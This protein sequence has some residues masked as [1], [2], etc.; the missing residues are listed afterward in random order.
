MKKP[1]A[2]GMV[3]T[4][5]Y[6]GA[7]EKL[8]SERLQEPVTIGD[9]HLSLLP[10]PQLKLQ[11]IVIGGNMLWIA[12]HAGNE[13]VDEALVHIF[14]GGADIDAASTIE[15]EMSTSSKP[16]TVSPRPETLRLKTCI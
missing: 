11:R 8:L 15:P 1:T 9:L 7:I 10:A 13:G 5:G 16:N 3:E 2:L 12:C 6:V 14:F 4:K